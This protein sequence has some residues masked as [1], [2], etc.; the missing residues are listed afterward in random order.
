MISKKVQQILDRHNAYRLS[1]D[2]R[3]NS[4]EAIAERDAILK[5]YNEGEAAI[6]CGDCGHIEKFSAFETAQDKFKC[7]KCGV[8]FEIKRD[9]PTVLESGFVMPGK[10]HIEKIY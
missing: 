7:P 2:A 10:I 3:L 8:A 5:A 9:P 1:E 6:T 4:P